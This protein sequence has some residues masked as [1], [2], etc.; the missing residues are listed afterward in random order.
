ML[1]YY[2]FA[3]IPVLQIIVLNLLNIAMLI[4]QGQF[5]PLNSIFK[6]RIELM[7]EVFITT[8]SLHLMCFTDWLSFENQDTMGLSIVI[9]IVV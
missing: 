2:Y 3:V 5:A 9:L 1:I 6:N 7:N 8:A 4:Y